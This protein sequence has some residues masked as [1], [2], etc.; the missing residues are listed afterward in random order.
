MILSCTLRELTSFLLP[1]KRGNLLNP[2]CLLPL[3]GKVGMGVKLI[4]K[5]GW[6]G[7]KI[8]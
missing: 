3:W 1:V 2:V 5:E 7:G 4:N 8:K 6:D